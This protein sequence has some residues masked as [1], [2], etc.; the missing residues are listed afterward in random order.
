ML[1]KAIILAAGR[2]TRVQ[3]PTHDMSKPTS[4]LAGKPVMQHSVEQ[5][6]RQGVREIMVDVSHM[7]DRVERCFVNAQ[8]FG[9]QIGD[10]FEGHLDRDRFVPGPFG[11]AGAL[12]RNQDVGG[13]SGFS[14]ETTAVSCGDAVIDPNTKLARDVVATQ[15]PVYI[16]SAACIEPGVV[17]GES[18]WT[19]PGVSGCGD[20]GTSEGARMGLRQ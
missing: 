14:D 4:T 6:A 17:L 9:V 13:S 10:S 8:R 12:R 19:G 18:M 11:S 7:A 5:L 20:E 1:S 15:G 16:S 3:P 2:D